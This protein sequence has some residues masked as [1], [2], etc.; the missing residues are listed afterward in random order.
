MLRQAQA[1]ASAEV[2]AASSAAVVEAAVDEKIGTAIAGDITT[3]P[4]IAEKL[5][6]LDRRINEL[7]QIQ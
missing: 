2:A 5:E 1:V 6:R 4:F 3:N 7:E